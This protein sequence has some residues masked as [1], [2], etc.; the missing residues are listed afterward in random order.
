MCR[1]YKYYKT[2]TLTQQFEVVYK[3]KLFNLNFYKLKQHVTGIVL[4][5]LTTIIAL[6]RDLLFLD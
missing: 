1:V 6:I 4:I 2:T 5:G 3:I